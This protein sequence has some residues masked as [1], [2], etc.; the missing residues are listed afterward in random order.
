TH[1][2]GFDVVLAGGDGHDCAEQVIRQQ[3]SPNLFVNHLGRLA[4]QEAQ[5]QGACH[6]VYL[7]VEQMAD[8]LEFLKGR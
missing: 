5:P 4:T 7:T 1:L 8:V 6:R 3:V 2:A